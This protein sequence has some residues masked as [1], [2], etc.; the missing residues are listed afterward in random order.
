M[1]HVKLFFLMALL[2]AL[3]VAAGGILGGSQMMVAAL[4]FAALMNFG[5]YWYSD[6]AVLRMYRAQVVTREQAPELYEMVDRLRRRAGL[7]MPTVAVAPSDQPNAFATGRS[8]DRAV[9]CFTRG[10]LNLVPQ[11]ELEGVTAHE[12]A[13]I[14]N[15]DML[16][17]TTAA[18]MAGAI[19]LL[20]RFA[21][22]IPIGGHG[23]DRS[24]L[25]GIAL[26]IVAPL[27]A[28][29]VHMAVSRTMEYRADRVG[30]EIA[31]K[32]LGLAGALRRLEAYAKRIPMEVN[33]A[34]AHLCIVN[35]LRG[36]GL[37]ALFRTHPP[38]EERVRRLEA[39]ARGR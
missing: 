32:P 5:I 17:G 34:A 4:V 24:P 12:L 28:L 38:T 9:V 20:S 7:P 29:L 18:T 35:P 3:I 22:F 31:G 1:T 14:A 6:K 39:M 27:A 23:R 30:A 15:R 16:I 10:I 8:P 36:G 37:V 26:L 19:T 2:T 25:A 11:E 33:P 21:W 13:H